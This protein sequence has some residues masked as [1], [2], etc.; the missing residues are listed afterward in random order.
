MPTKVSKKIE[1]DLHRPKW[2][3]L[4]GESPRCFD[5]I[6]WVDM[7]A[8]IFR[9]SQIIFAF[10]GGPPSPSTSKAAYLLAK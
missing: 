10:K 3:G 5:V 1:K 6:Y 4:V 2:K 9:D 7:S 8:L